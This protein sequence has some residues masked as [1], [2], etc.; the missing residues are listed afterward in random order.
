MHAAKRP[1]A[2]K[3]WA[4]GLL[5]AAA[6]MA[7]GTAVAADA[8][9]KAAP[10]KA[11][12]YKAPRNAFGQPDLSGAW[13]NA[14]L[15]PMMRPAKFGT[16]SVMT[17]DEIHAAEEAAEVE[18]E[19]GN[20]ETDP[21]ADAEHRQKFS[22]LKPEYAAAGGDTG[23]YDRGWL[24]P[25]SSVMRVN[26]EA[27][28]SLI[29][30]PNGQPPARKPGAPPAPR[31]GGGMGSFDSY[32]ARSLGERCIMSFGRNA[33]P[34]ML[35]NGF[36]NNNYQFVQTAD[37]F[38]INVEM[39]HDTRIVRLNARHRTDGVRSY[40]GDSIGW[41]EGDTLVVETT[42]FLPNQQW[43]GSWENLKVTER[44]TRVG[45][46]RVRYAFQAEDP[47]IWEKPWG[48]EY[49]FYALNGRVYEYACHEGNYALPGILAGARAQEEEARKAAAAAPAPAPTKA[50]AKAGGG[51]Q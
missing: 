25:G 16:R 18:V 37:A 3:T 33:G 45:D 6:P 10:A 22:N 1:F 27:R 24:D 36:Y 46:K 11:A 49:E 17:P 15:T 30:T 29:T 50:G 39:I 32:E 31:F 34:P 42:N 12:A 2:A 38:V 4:F 20:A 51:A 9:A 35:P 26:G 28:T 5:I 21:N 8:P 40:M 7:P 44:F 43:M 13:S 47:T 48:G 14:T 19:E 41:W 23:G